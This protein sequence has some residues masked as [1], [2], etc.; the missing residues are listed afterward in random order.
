MSIMQLEIITIYCLCEDFLAVYGQKDDV[1]TQF[2]SSE[3][4]TAA[5]VS[6]WFFAGNQRMTCLFLKQHGYMPKMVSESRF[7]RRLHKIP[8]EL[9]MSLFQVVAEV[10]KK[11]NPTNEYI[12]DSCPVPVC[13]NLRI[14]RSRIY[15][16]KEHGLN[17]Y[18][19]FC[20]S[21][22]TYF[23][24]IKIHLV[25]ASNGKP[26]DVMFTP[27][28]TGDMPG[29]RSLL[30]DLPAESEL[31]ADKGYTDYQFEDSLLELANI[32]LIAA[33]KNN[34]KRQH[35]GHVSYLCQVIR[36]RIES[37]FSDLNKRLARNIHAVTARGFELKVFMT[38]LALTILG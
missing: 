25:V 27:G 8:E 9:W 13:N 19:G 15:R 36:K 34:S 10:H 7:N 14:M 21:K 32:E 2:S 23:Y 37:T 3:V 35:L 6:A 1:Q 4:M 20:A 38:V 16:V 33:R 26:V 24:G 5:L 31:Y 12:V 22:R 17:K 11:L 18:R 28:S 30:L 29:L